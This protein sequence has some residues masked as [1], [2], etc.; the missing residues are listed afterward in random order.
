MGCCSVFSGRVPAALRSNCICSG[1]HLLD[2]LEP[3]GIA[4]WLF[5][6]PFCFGSFPQLYPFLECISFSQITNGLPNILSILLHN[7]AQHGYQRPTPGAADGLEYLS[8]HSCREC[9]VIMASKNRGVDGLSHF[10]LPKNW[11][12]CLY[13]FPGS[14][15]LR[16]I[17]SSWAKPPCKLE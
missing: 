7:W 13:R 2:P 15:V 5:E 3:S 9:G 10:Q 16:E 8:F 17:H 6:D 4:F 12:Y 1:L 14:H 11:L